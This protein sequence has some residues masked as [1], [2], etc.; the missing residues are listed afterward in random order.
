MPSVLQLRT[1]A[2]VKSPARYNEQVIIN[3][4]LNEFSAN[5][6][7]KKLSKKLY[8]IYTSDTTPVQS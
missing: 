1:L 5:P 3:P 6:L 7:I 8:R 2:L 4:P